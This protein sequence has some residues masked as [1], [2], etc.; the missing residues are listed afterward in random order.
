MSQ[1]DFASSPARGLK[2]LSSPS[3]PT[4]LISVFQ[5]NIQA[6]TPSSDVNDAPPSLINGLAAREFKFGES[7]DLARMAP[8]VAEHLLHPYQKQRQNSPF[9]STPQQHAPSYTIGTNSISPEEDTTQ[10]FPSPSPTGG[11]AKRKRKL[12]C[13]NKPLM[14]AAAVLI[15]IKQSPED[16]ETTVNTLIDNYPKKSIKRSDDLA[17]KNT[18]PRSNLKKSPGGAPKPFSLIAPLSVSDSDNNEGVI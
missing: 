1:A 3:S 18:K 14:E 15:A 16:I 8:T 4:K 9:S 10:S 11:D 13:R 17:T 2:I 6:P 7:N 12:V 5:A